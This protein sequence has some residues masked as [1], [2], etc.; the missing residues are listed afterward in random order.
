MFENQESTILYKRF[1]Y[2][3]ILKVKE[4]YFPISN[5]HSFL[6]LSSSTSQFSF[7]H[8]LFLLNLN[9][10]I[11][12]SIY[13]A[14]LKLIAIL[15]S[16][17]PKRWNCRVM[18][19]CTTLLPWVLNGYSKQ[20]N[21]KF[22]KKMTN[23]LQCSQY[24]KEY[25]CVITLCFSKNIPLFLP[26]CAR[27]RSATGTNA[28]GKIMQQTGSKVSG[29][30]QQIPMLCTWSESKYHGGRGI[31]WYRIHKE[32]KRGPGHIIDS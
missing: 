28:W 8:L 3:E 31:M 10:S 21:K 14:S 12:F 4:N 15:L 16:L 18:S 19:P 9:Y 11:C 6:E 25:S 23:I 7:T 27:L 20:R 22:W 30:G 5:C 26:P 1:F 32:R 13:V 17:P 24:S 29:Q 2:H